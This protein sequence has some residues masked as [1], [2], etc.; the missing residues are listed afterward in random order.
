MAPCRSDGEFAKPAAGERI[1]A[2]ARAGK[3][4]GNRNFGPV[5]HVV[6]PKHHG[7]SGFGTLPQT[8]GYSGCCRKQQR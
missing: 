5:Q 6:K 4:P 1:V 3:P 7:F 8:T 2:F